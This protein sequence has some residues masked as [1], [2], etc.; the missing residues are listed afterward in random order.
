MGRV[1]ASTLQQ[2][3]GFADPELTTPTHD[4]LC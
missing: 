1:K 2:R 3:F 4:A